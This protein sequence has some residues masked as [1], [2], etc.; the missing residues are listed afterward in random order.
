MARYRIRGPRLA[1][2]ARVTI[3]DPVLVPPTA[4]SV[5]SLVF[6]WRSVLAQRVRSSHFGTRS[7]LS[8]KIGSN[9]D[10]D[11]RGELESA[12]SKAVAILGRHAAAVGGVLFFLLAASQVQFH[13]VYEFDPDEGNNLLKSLMLDR[14]FGFGEIWSDQP[15][16][17]SYL[18][19]AVFKIFGWHVEVGRMLTLAFAAALV[20]AVYDLLRLEL[21]HLA[22]SGAVIL[23]VFSREFI[24]RSVCVM[25]GLPAIALAVLGVWALRRWQQRGEGRWLVLSGFFLGCSV[26]TKMFTA[27]IVPLCALYVAA[28][29]WSRSSKPSWLRLGCIWAAAFALTALAA[30]SPALFSAHPE[31]LLQA[32][33]AG[34]GLTTKWL[35]L[36]GSVVVPDFFRAEWP[37][38][39][40]AA[41]GLVYALARRRAVGL[42][43]GSWLGVAAAVLLGHY[44]VWPH[45]RLLLSVPASALGG[46]AIGG[47]IQESR[48]L[49]LR[50]LG[51]RGALVAAVAVL[52]GLT[53]LGVDYRDL[54]E[55]PF[56]SDNERDRRVEAEIRKY[57]PSTRTMI[58]SR[59]M[60]AFRVGLS[61]P[62]DLAVTSYK[63]FV[64]RLLTAQ[65]ILRDVAV[66]APE[67]VLLSSRWSGGIRNQLRDAL[68]RDYHRVYRD[69]RNHNV[70]LY[71]KKEVVET[72]QRRGRQGL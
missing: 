37:L 15:P 68:R 38:F 29:A 33:V 40:L 59:P 54:F 1:P 12:L 18:L 4:K 23:M 9:P 55:L 3:P 61:T 22:A 2:Y 60:Y 45:H 49:W 32:H 51:S 67:Q 64:T 63:R 36:H 66:Y 25:L 27:F 50:P 56:R 35:R 53:R 19:L 20:F 43:F 14:G 13:D 52:L 31:Q 58:T 48:S 71:V 28:Y 21:G 57:A 42:L 17:F 8:T 46:L 6:T 5:P 70:E 69:R 11:S 7:D 62:P 41:I 47:L 16:L 10:F 34:R 39:G 26:A 72:Y 30:L 24:L 44:P 65:S